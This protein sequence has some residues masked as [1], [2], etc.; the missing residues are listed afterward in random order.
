MA[1]S[2]SGGGDATGTISDLS[3]ANVS[4]LTTLT[5][6]VDG[7]LGIKQ[8]AASLVDV[9]NISANDSVTLGD[10]TIKAT[11]T[12]TVSAIDLAGL[13]DIAG[14]TSTASA[15]S[16]GTTGTPTATL[17]LGQVTVDGQ[18]AY[19]DDKGV[20]IPTSNPSVAGITPQ[21]LQ[22]TVDATLAQDG[23]SIRGPRPQADNERCR[24]HGDRRRLA[25]GHL[26]PVRHPIHSRRTHHPVARAGQ[27]GAAGR[28]LHGHHL[29][30]LRAGPSECGGVGGPG[31]EQRAAHHDPTDSSLGGSSSTFPDTLGSTFPGGS[32]QSLAA[33]GPGSAAGSGVTQSARPIT[34][35]TAFP[36]KGS[37]GAG[38]V[39]RRRLL[40]CVLIAYPLL[41]LARWQFTG[42]RSG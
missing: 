3:L 4:L 13:V 21:Q 30:H 16:D 38:G 29:G 33:T 8:S 37:A 36:I 14:L 20:H 19:I 9:G 35:G 27:R 2:S 25:G 5:K 42:G 12:T 31:A 7:V 32:V 18:S 40:A 11:S 22:Q 1:D 23:V 15:V 34:T 6:G 28:S 39:G 24:S 41:L 10:S 17:H 26:P